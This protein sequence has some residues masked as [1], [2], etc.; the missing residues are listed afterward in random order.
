M[1][2]KKTIPSIFYLACCS[3][4]FLFV[5]K[6]A[7]QGV[8]FTATTGSP[9][10]GLQ[11]Q[12]QITF[13]LQD[14]QS[15][16]AIKTPNFKDFKVVGGPYQSSSSNMMVSGNKMVQSQ[17]FSV[18]FNL[19]AKHVGTFTIAPATADDGAG[20]KYQSNSVKVEVVEGSIQPRQRAIAGG[21]GGFWDQD[22]FA[23]QSQQQAARAQAAAQPKLD[24]GN[25]IFI[26]V[27]VDKKNVKLGEQ[28]TAVYKLYARIPMQ[29]AISKLPSLNGFWTQD[30]DIPKQQKPV[31]EVINGQKYQTFVLK[32]S[33]LF[34]QQSGKLILDVAE[35]E[36]T[37][38]VPV[39]IQHRSLFDDPFF[40]QAFGGTLMMSDPM[41]N[42]PFAESGYQQVPVHLKSQPVT[43][44][45]SELPTQGKPAT[46]TGAVGTFAIDG[47]LD[48]TELTTDDVASL[49]V[50][51]SGSGNLKLF[52]PP[53]LNLPSGLDSYDP[54]ILDTIMGRT[55]TISGEKIVTYS[56]APRNPGSYE[57]PPITLSFYNP[58]TNKYESVST[59]AFH[60]TVKPGKGVPTVASKAGANGMDIQ[61]NILS[62]VPRPLISNP[63]FWSLFA[64]PGLLLFG[65]GYY[66]KREEENDADTVQNRNRLANK[67]AQK[68]LTA[69]GTMLQKGD[70]RGFYT[71][72][73]K[74]IW[75]Y[76]SDKL[77]I[78]ISCLSR[79]TARAGMQSGQVP[80]PIQEQVEKLLNECEMALYAPSGDSHQMQQTY[81][82]AA[83]IITN[84]ERTLRTS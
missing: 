1:K 40:K 51:I 38:H 39:K 78:P 27:N 60:L 24:I 64:I 31:E 32:K 49:K 35:A 47:Q 16:G 52:T 54:N 6:A 21:G 46:F 79:D 48:K 5:Q 37:A 77:N 45:V 11:D 33:A 19:Q 28:V 63:G 69:A 20:H 2:M 42:D 13:T 72:I 81:T 59:K 9:K 65:V 25:A 17:S 70:A 67:V 80:Q 50:T 55:T 26:K 61:D 58:Q 84:L 23:N 15:V 22:P 7:A 30:F 82:E 43:I 83:G 8:S 71:E 76:L 74:S 41:F 57:I 44:N 34:P 18:S 29:V 75:L 66:R 10:V 62:S 56:V 68:R 12:F 36:G 73:S 4:V 3:I 14:A 53:A